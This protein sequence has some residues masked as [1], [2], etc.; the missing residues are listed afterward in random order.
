[1]ANNIETGNF[2]GEA[3]TVATTE[4]GAVHTPHH[5]DPEAIALLQELADGQ[6]SG[7][8]TEA[9][10]DAIVAA[11]TALAGFV[12]GLEAALGTELTAINR[13]GTRAYG[14]ASRV[15][16]AASTAYSG[17]IMAT[18]VMLHASVK[19]YVAIVAATGTPTVDPAAA[20]PLEAG[21]KFHLRIS[22]GLRIATIRD[23]ADGFLHIA[24][25]V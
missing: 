15:A 17:V 14:T 19:Q 11:L 5:R 21:E 3:V 7:V 8:A 9:K 4:T 12:D 20:I 23:T 10:Q 6:P 13:I 24:P 2:A 22:S 18:E 25:V 1:M 16:V